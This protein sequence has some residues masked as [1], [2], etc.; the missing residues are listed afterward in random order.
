[1]YV[2]KT[3]TPSQVFLLT[4]TLQE[5]VIYNVWRRVHHRLQLLLFQ[6][7]IRLRGPCD[8]REAWLD[9]L[10]FRSRQ[11][12]HLYLEFDRELPFTF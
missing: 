4:T 5:L 8:A 9:A 10:H 6:R 7:E 1:M 3:I 2:V 12:H 11:L